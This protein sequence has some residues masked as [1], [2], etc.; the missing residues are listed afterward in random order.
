MVLPGVVELFLLLSVPSSCR[1]VP[2]RIKKILLKIRKSAGQTFK[3]WRAKQGRTVDVKGQETTT[4]KE[5]KS[6]EK[7]TMKPKESK[8]SEKP[9]QKEKEKTKEKKK[10]EETFL[11]KMF[12]G[13]Q[14]HLTSKAEVATAQSPWPRL[15]DS[16]IAKILE[17]ESEGGEKKL[18]HQMKNRFPTKK[19]KVGDKP[20]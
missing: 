12:K 9:K 15:G 8:T 2:T 1:P 3:G 13:V 16:N 18:S 20:S 17:P 6:E 14:K 7:S 4:A 19:M 5:P 11:A 10:G